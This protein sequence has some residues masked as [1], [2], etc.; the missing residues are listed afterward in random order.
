MENTQNIPVKNKRAISV[1]DILNYNPKVMD[2]EGKWL[3]SFGRPEMSGSWII[4][5]SSGSGKTRFSLDLAKYLTNFGKVAY[6]SLEQGLSLSLK[7]A[8][9]EAGMI[10]V[11][12]RFIL[13][14]KE[15]VEDLTQ[16]LKKHKSPD[17]IF[18]DSVQYSGLNKDT[19][20]DLVDGFRKKLFIFVS[21]SEG[22]KPAGR[23]AKSI[24]FHSD[25]KLFIDGFV[26]KENINRFIKGPPKPFVTWEDGV[27]NDL[28]Q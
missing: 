22:S 26:I 19:A 13:L 11:S 15:D 3:D 4:Y 25:I 23:T 9:E 2:F 21:H 8:I 17:I 18:I 14:D 7:T 20:M 6:N 1:R 27:M 16:R 24:K 5:G 10:D 12:R 28:N